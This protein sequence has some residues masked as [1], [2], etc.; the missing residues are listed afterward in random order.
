MTHFSR[1]DFL[2]VGAAGTATV[3]LA[4][5]QSHERWV[6]LEP[7]VRAP[8]EQVAGVANWYASTCRLCPAGCGIVVRVMNGRAVKIEGSPDHPV[9][10]GKLCAR[11][12]AGLHL[13]YNPD[14]VTGAVRQ[15]KRGER[16]FKP[17]HW[18]EGINT[19][20]ERL[21]FAGDK[22]AVWIGGTT[23]GHVVDLFTR[24]TD[25]I[26]APPPVRYDLY[27]GFHGYH[28]LA[29]HSETVFERGGLP[30]YDLGRAD[31]IFSFGADFLG[32]WLSSTGYGIKYGQFRS[33]EF[34][35]RGY[36]VQF[37]PR[38]ST[39]GAVADRWVPVLPG[40]DALVAQALVTLI[41]EEK[42]GSPERVERAKALAGDV[43]VESAAAACETSVEELVKLARVFA[44]ADHPIAIPG[45]ALTGQNN[46]M[47]AIAAV[48]ALNIVAGSGGMMLGG[49]MPLS[50]QPAADLVGLTLSP[51]ADAQTLI[52]RMI[53]G[54][55][56][57]LLVHGA[58]PAYD[59]P[60]ETGFVDAL[61][62]VSYI[63]S[64]NPM[65][66]E[67]TRWAD[68]VLPDRTYLEGWGYVIPAPVVGGLPTVSSQQPV[69]PPLYDVH[70]TADVLLTVTKGFPAAAQALPWTDEVA[71]LKEIITALPAGAAGGE[72]ADVRWA[73]YLQTGGWWPE[74]APGETA[75]PP[76]VNEP[77]AVA[78]TEY[79]GDE[80]DYPYHLY[81]YMPVA[82]SDGSGANS[83]W[84]QGTPDPMTTISWQTWA[85]I[86][87][88]TAKELDVENGDVV[89]ITSP[90]GELK[91]PV[92][93][94]PA[95]RPDTVAIPLGQGHSDYGRYA[96]KRGHNPLKL[97]G[98]Q[99]DASGDYLAWS[100]VRVSIKRTGDHK[101]LALF[102]STIEP[103]EF[104]HDPV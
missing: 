40:A 3:I 44:T 102:E 93:V 41:A 60:Q 80:N 33:Q 101:T 35:K 6:E 21:E 92:Y 51:Y 42:L 64:F 63:V 7:Y 79:Q 26:G 27:T 78:P 65:V 87:P 43:D 84:L 98:S 16:K 55:V 17:I 81:L 37:E 25:A 91:V 53:N 49:L 45:S 82:L 14:R 39:T 57:M 77:V 73:R 32:T 36:L 75:P 34:G 38:M 50:E 11:G 18:N 1:R 100:T 29:H 5:C 95:V 88:K 23:P 97:I 22:V 56:Y 59:L 15:E 94:Y 12:Q 69:V 31:A 68:L 66:D 96:R 76:A 70:S 62:N 4:G 74:S 90:Y 72:D 2:K 54:D 61:E 9:N 13:L 58:N 10:R 103:E 28:A 47:E 85:E 52:D 99:T 89:T 24:F 86:N 71:F 19:L 48:Q 46:G 67:T 104:V 8:E 20:V 83:P 30:T